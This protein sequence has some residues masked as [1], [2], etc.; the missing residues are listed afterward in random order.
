MGVDVRKITGPARRRQ[1]RQGRRQPS[2]ADLLR[3]ASHQ[4]S[5]PLTAC[6][7]SIEL[8]LLPGRSHKDCLAACR[9]ALAAAEQMVM[10]VE[11]LRDLPEGHL[12]SGLLQSVF[13]PWDPTPRKQS[14]K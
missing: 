13:R 2:A 9:R 10:I 11:Y 12:A 1:R 14:T 8:A 6:R 4:L 7:G 5:Q 3:A